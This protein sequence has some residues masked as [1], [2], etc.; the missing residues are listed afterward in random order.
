MVILSLTLIAH[1]EAN[2]R[3][4]AI[5]TYSTKM[6]GCGSTRKREH[7]ERNTPATFRLLTRRKM[8]NS[9]SFTLAVKW[10]DAG[11]RYNNS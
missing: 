6:L 7:D 10:N 1:D 9:V 11:P 2:G 8:S 3:M 4:A 5:L